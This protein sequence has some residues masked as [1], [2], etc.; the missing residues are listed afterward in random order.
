MKNLSNNYS[1]TDIATVPELNSYGDIKTIHDRV[2]VKQSLTNIIHTRPGTRPF[3]PSFGYAVDDLLFDMA[4]KQ[5]TNALK[6]DFVNT[7]LRFEPRIS[8]VEAIFEIIDETL[9]IDV[10]YTII[11]TNGQDSIQTSLDRS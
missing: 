11:N 10:R 6:K 7:L 8:N 2:A 3:M 5:V 4:D 1:Y 9:N